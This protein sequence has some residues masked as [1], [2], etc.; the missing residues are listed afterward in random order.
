ML[1]ADYLFSQVLQLKIDF[2]RVV[3]ESTPEEFQDI[4][5][6]TRLLHGLRHPIFFSKSCLNP[7]VTE[8]EMTQS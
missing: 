3:V 2:S 4:S 6:N 8:N 5:S 7:S 1:K